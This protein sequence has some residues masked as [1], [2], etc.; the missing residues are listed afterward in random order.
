MYYAL[1]V[2]STGD[3]IRYQD[4]DGLPPGLADEKGLHWV[5]EDP[6]PSAHVLQTRAAEP[7][8]AKEQRDFE[9][10]IDDDP[11]EAIK[12]YIFHRR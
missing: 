6:P 10:K 5:Q 4:F 2:I 12:Q 8:A 1:K 3:V 9:E 7:Y 11:I